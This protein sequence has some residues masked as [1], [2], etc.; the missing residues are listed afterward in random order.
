LEAEGKMIDADT[1]EIFKKYK[2]TLI[3]E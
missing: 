2:E 1:R 3:E